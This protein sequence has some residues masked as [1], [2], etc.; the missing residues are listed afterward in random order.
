MDLFIGMCIT[1][2]HPIGLIQ[3][4]KLR[5]SMNR[6]YNFRKSDI[7]QRDQKLMLL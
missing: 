5:I 3:L 2:I 7:G 1:G 6:F 4:K